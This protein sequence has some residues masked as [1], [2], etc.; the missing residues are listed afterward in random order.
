MANAESLHFLS[1][2]E[3]RAEPFKKAASAVGKL[4]KNQSTLILTHG[5]FSL[6]D[7]IQAI[8][9]QLDAPAEIVVATWTAA[10]VEIDSA[11]E[12]IAHKKIKSMRWIVDNSFLARQPAYHQLLVE[13]FGY[14]SI[15]TIKTHIKFCLIRSDE[16]RIAIRTSMNLNTNPRLELIELSDSE[17]IYNFFGDFADRL[18]AE[19]PPAEN[20]GL[21]PAR[22]TKP[23]KSTLDKR[24][25]ER[26]VIG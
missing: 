1:T 3:L 14:D 25:L 8:L 7:A 20:W 17:S 26:R 11:A 13:R 21:P 5:Q 10:K 15:R 23:I 6:S 16:W 2:P 12:M 22:I 24:T 4:T 19:Q 9:D 18:F